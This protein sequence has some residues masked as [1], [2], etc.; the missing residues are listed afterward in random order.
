[1]LRS[2]MQTTDT[3]RRLARFIAVGCLAA[4]VHWMVV[5]TLVDQWKWHPLVA[6]VI[7]WLVA[8]V[9][10]FTGHH[11]LTFKGHGAAPGPAALRFFMVSA[12]GFVV[13]E[14]AYALLLQWSGHRYAI[15]LAAVLIGV[16]GVTYLLGRHWVFLGS[17]APLP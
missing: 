15:V 14:C 12:L 4:T 8:F 11:R 2:T 16:A 5:V 13:N 7:G 6:N 17:P 9:V 3:Q 10:S 1:M